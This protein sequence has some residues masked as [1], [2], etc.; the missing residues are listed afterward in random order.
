MQ[1]FE[2]SSTVNDSCAADALNNT[3]K[4]TLLLI[5]R[6]NSDEEVQ[7]A[8]Q[9]L[10]GLLALSQTDNESLTQ[11]LHKEIRNRKLLEDKLSSSEAKLRGIIESIKDIILVVSIQDKKLSNV[12]IL[13]TC[14]SNAD[15][16]TNKLI[17]KTAELF[18]G[19]ET[20]QLFLQQVEQALDTQK[21]L[22]IDY[23]LQEEDYQVWFTAS[24][25][26]ISDKSVLWVA[27]DITQRKTAE[28]AL[29]E[30]EE[31][32][33]AVYEQAAV[34]IFMVSL[35]GE[36]I[37][38]NP[39]FCEIIGYKEELLKQVS[40]QDITHQDDIEAELMHVRQLFTNEISNYSLQKRFIR[41][42]NRYYQEQWVNVS[43]SLVR[44]KQ[45]M[46]D[47]FLGVVEDISQRKWTEDA[48]RESE[49]RFCA[50]F[51][52]ASVG[53]YQIKL[54]GEFIEVN[55]HFC[56][57]IG[58]SESELLDLSWQDITDLDN[59]DSCMELMSNILN[60]KTNANSIHKQLIHKNGDF[61]RL[62]V[63][64]SVISD[65]N[66]TPQYF[67]CIAQKLLSSKVKV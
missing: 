46:P 42:W 51:E 20:A 44:N 9:K 52:Q 10:Q 38:V 34:G 55:P 19:E 53:I 5:S 33:R 22:H 37:E 67:L 57:I 7:L 15:A 12:E 61:I 48:L 28:E 21:N 65:G 24:I 58:Y 60:H 4:E 63:S 49:E 3:I 59:L 32:F 39:R 23:Q 41:K 54:S 56:E 16:T 18:F 26:P 35:Y 29:R 36:F 40:W 62:K 45:G 6:R 14:A 43:V 47:Y 2:N 8:L 27:R 31:R 17:N 13:P 30:S 66:G 64:I 25:S 50:I 11:K 1:E